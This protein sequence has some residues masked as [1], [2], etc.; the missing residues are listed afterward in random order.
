[1]ASF[2]YREETPRRSRLLTAQ[3]MV[4]LVLFVVIAVALV[5]QGHPTAGFSLLAIS[6]LISAMDA[7]R[8]K[9]LRK[10]TGNWEI[11]IDNESFRWSSPSPSLGPTVEIPIKAIKSLVVTSL[12][13]SEVGSD[14]RY[15]LILE[16]G[17][18]MELW[19][20]DSAPMD[21]IM[22]CLKSNSVTLVRK[23]A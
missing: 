21:R 11:A 8:L 13:W 17:F 4:V 19:G 2:Y 22:E 16:D 14:K 15:Q 23:N 20:W 7:L 12:A 9:R 1:M 5:V 3:T 6:V 10:A 18:H